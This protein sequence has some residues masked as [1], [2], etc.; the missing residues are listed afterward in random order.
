MGKMLIVLFAVPLMLGISCCDKPAPVLISDDSF[1]VPRIEFAPE[2][3]VCYRAEKTLEIDGKADEVAWQAA[4]WTDLF[5]DIEGDRKPAPRFETRVKMLW[6][7]EYF[8]FAGKMEEPDVWAKLTHRDAIIFY[9]NDFE[10]FIDPDGDTHEY[11]ELEVNA[12]ST[13]WDLFLVKPYRDGAPA[14]HSWDIQG[15]KTVV[16]VDGTLNKP[17]DKDRGWTIEIAIPW[18][19]M[20]ECAHKESPPVEGDQWRVNFSR[21]EWQTEVEDGEYTKVLDPESGKP[22]PEDNWVWSPQGLINMHYPEMWGFVQFS[23]VSV[24][25][26]ENAFV[27]NPEEDAKWALRQVYY[28]QRTYQMQYGEYTAQYDRLELEVAGPAGYEWPPVLETTSAQ[29]VATIK[30]LDSEKELHISHLGKTW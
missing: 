24:G 11:Y 7:D 14:L 1:E 21:V 26:G 20:K 8:Y 2:T 16:S 6:D 5:V 18:A 15:L 9:D 29:F 30:K 23:T 17:G 28:A 10:V 22:L 12:F 3:Y 19:V 27:V 4:E 25:E 13:E